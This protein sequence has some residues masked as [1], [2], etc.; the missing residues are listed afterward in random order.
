M[1]FNILL[2][3]FVSQSPHL[4]NGKFKLRTSKAYVGFI[5]GG[6]GNHF[7]DDQVQSLFSVLSGC[8]IIQ[9]KSWVSITILRPL[10][11]LWDQ[12]SR[13]EGTNSNGW[14]Y[15]ADTEL[16]EKVGDKD[17]DDLKSPSFS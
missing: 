6:F 4:W 9:A 8:G 2:A 10:W 7:F 15:L 16:S 17:A 3:L 5:D 11:S 1:A 12:K 13:P 14:C